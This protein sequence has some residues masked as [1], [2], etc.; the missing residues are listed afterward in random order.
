MTEA[1]QGVERIQR[2]V[3][4][5]SEQRL[6]AWLCPRLP[7]ALTPDVLTALA[8]VSA[9]LSGAGYWLSNL[10]PAWLW[11]AAIGYPL[12]WFGDSLDGT[13]ARYRRVERPRYGYF[14]DHSCDGLAVL[15]IFGGLG[16]SPY[17]RMDVALFAVAAYLLLAVHTFLRAKVQGDF[18]LSHM[19][20]G[21]TEGRLFMIA[22]TAAMGWLGPDFGRVGAY[23]AF[24]LLFGAMAAI[25]VIVFVVQTLQTGRVLARADRAARNG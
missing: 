6:L 4:A 16:L 24:D 17:M 7:K 13:I 8:M 2:S 20:A 15:V 25:L 3:L 11:L 18:L 19:G 1:L 22:L 21:P 14:I 12:H 9:F 5:R 23:N 10:D